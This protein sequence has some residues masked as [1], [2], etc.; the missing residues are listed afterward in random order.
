MN[1]LHFR[2]KSDWPQGPWINEPNK[3]HWIDEE[4][5]YDCLIRRTVCGALCGYVGIKENHSFYKKGHDLLNGGV[6]VHGRLSYS[7]LCQEDEKVTGICHLSENED[8]VWWFGFDC[9]HGYDLLPC[10]RP[11]HIDAIHALYD[12]IDSL[13]NAELYAN[14]QTYKD[15]NYVK[16]EIKSLAKQL[17]ELEK[18]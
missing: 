9:D 11:Q 5:G 2:D 18:E 1:E 3:V 15:I 10:R 14:D 17:K 8:K 7:D 12:T 13:F 4:S 16:N 6:A